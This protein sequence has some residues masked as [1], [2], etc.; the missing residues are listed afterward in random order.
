MILVEPAG[1]DQAKIVKMEIQATQGLPSKARWH[2]VQAVEKE[3][4]SS[5]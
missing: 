5:L 4:D 2:L 1:Q 3:R